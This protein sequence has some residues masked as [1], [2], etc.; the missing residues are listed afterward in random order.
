MNTLPVVLH[1]VVEHDVVSC[2]VS[3]LPLGKGPCSLLH[4]TMGVGSPLASQKKCADSPR[5]TETSW[6]S[7]SITGFSKEQRHMGPI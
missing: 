4:S 6:G 1:N 7:R 2:C 5:L 3:N